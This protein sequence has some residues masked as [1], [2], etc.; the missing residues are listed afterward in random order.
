MRKLV[1]I[2]F[3]LSVYS[4]YSQNIFNNTYDGNYPGLRNIIVLEDGYVGLGFEYFTDKISIYIVKIDFSGEMIWSKAIGDETY[5][6]YHGDRNSLIENDDGG[7]SLAGARTGQGNITGMLTK[8][9]QNFDTLWTRLYFDNP[10]FTAFYNHIQTPDGGYALVGSN[11]ET[12]PDGDVLLVKSDSEGNMEWYKK[13]G[14][15]DRDIGLCIVESEDGGY[16]I[17]GSTDALGNIDGYLLKVDSFGNLDW[18]KHFGNPLY[19][20]G[21]IYTILKTGNN[22]YYIALS[23]YVTDPISS[24]FYNRRYSIVKLD[25]DFNE[26]WNNVYGVRAEY[27]GLGTITC[28]SNG[29]VIATIADNHICGLMRISPDGDSLW[30]KYYT[31]E[32]SVG[33]AGL[34]AIKQTPD[35]GFIMAGVAY[36]PQVMWIVKT[37]SCGCVTE[38]CECGGSVVEKFTNELNIEVYPNPASD[39]INIKWNKVS[40]DAVLSIFSLSGQELLSK[41]IIDN[42][43]SLNISGLQS[44]FYIIQIKTKDKI[45][46]KKLQKL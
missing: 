12:D 35:N 33:E 28:A 40:Y 17:G 16:L 39:F 9:D 7:F 26:V 30:T 24:S 46:I 44:G 3:V 38:E 20:D 13:Y 18:T 6:Y 4:G 15:S 2:F 23:S 21:T 34:L 14:T 32:G 1:I 11:D 43:T 10:D 41:T 37:D 36:E 42:S 45:L 27:T 19:P 29:D 31:P 22:D 25:S 8:F 5:D